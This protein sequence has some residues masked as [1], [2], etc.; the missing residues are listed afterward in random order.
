MIASAD[1]Q[2]EFYMKKM[3]KNLV[4]AM[5][6]VMRVNNMCI[7]YPHPYQINRHVTNPITI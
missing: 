1:S 5:A 7:V 4:M 2:L 6:M 3:K